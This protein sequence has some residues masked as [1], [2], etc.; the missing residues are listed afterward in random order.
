[1]STVLSVYQALP[2]LVEIQFGGKKPHQPFCGHQ[3]IV[4]MASLSTDI[5]FSSSIFGLSPN[6]LPF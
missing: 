6:G 1:M 5:P 3:H 2:L 4:P